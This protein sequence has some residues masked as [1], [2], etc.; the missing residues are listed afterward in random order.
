MVKVD[1]SVAEPVSDA[2]RDQKEVIDQT[3]EELIFF[4]LFLISLGTACFIFQHKRCPR[5]LIHPFFK[6][7][8]FYEHSL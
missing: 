8:D 3:L 4:I 1:A 2:S 6:H 7:I 5:S